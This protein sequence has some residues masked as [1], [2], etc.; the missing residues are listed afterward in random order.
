MINLILLDAD[1]NYNTMVYMHAL[2]A[3]PK[4]GVDNTLF[5]RLVKEADA[6]GDGFID[7]NEFLNLM[8]KV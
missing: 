8:K 6:N 4:I 5:D 2:I 3:D 1:E 7:F